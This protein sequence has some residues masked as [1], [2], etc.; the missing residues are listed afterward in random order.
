MTLYIKSTCHPTTI[1]NTLL[2]WITIS[3]IR[4]Q[5]LQT[6]QN[7]ALKLTH[8][9]TF[10]ISNIYIHTITGIQTI[11]QRHHSMDIFED[12]NKH[13]CSPES[14]NKIHINR[15][16]PHIIVSTAGQSP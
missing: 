16:H 11:K 8:R 12:S 6:I 13:C 4:I 9:L 5:H 10:Y 14:Y 1:T 2:A 7:K 15:Y 3:D